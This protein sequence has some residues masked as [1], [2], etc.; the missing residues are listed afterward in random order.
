MKNFSWCSRFIIH[1]NI[2]S[3]SIWLSP[4]SPAVCMRVSRNSCKI[5]FVMSTLSNNCWL[6]ETIIAHMCIFDLDNNLAD[7]LVLAFIKAQTGSVGVGREEQSDVSGLQQQATVCSGSQAENHISFQVVRGEIF[8]LPQVADFDRLLAVT[9]ILEVG[10]PMMG[11]E[12]SR[13][14]SRTMQP[15]R[16]PNA[17]AKRSGCALIHAA[18]PV[19]FCRLL[20]KAGLR[21]GFLYT[22]FSGQYSTIVSGMCGLNGG[23]NANFTNK[24]AVFLFTSAAGVN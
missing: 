24:L 9:K 6:F 16:W 19:Q 22:S 15:G 2:G 10:M 17:G 20:R 21:P 5:D 4:F 23:W 13:D 1:R 14:D 8:L 18:C 3:R 11:F 12:P 7:Q